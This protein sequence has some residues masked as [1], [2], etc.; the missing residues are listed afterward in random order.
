MNVPGYLRCKVTLTNRGK[1]TRVWLQPLS[2][3][4][5]IPT[6]TMPEDFEDFWRQTLLQ[7]K[8][9]PLNSKLT[10]I[11]ELSDEKLDVYHVKFQNYKLG[12]YIY[13]VLSVP[14][15]EQNSALIK[16]LGAGVWSHFVSRHRC[17]QRNDCIGHSNS[18]N[19]YSNG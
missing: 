14:K 19:S 7:N 9:I 15:M 16:V 8:D 11:E 12:S 1:F 13:G 6:T 5:I 4:Q 2:S 17:S 3:H 10:K 18:W